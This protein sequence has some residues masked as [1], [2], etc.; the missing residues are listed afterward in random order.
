MIP[1]QDLGDPERFL[2]SLRA[3]ARTIDDRALQSD[4]AASYTASLLAS[5]PT[6]CARKLAEEAIETALAAAASD[7]G[8]TSPEAADLIY[9]LLVLLRSKG[10]ALDEVASI[11]DARSAMSGLDEKRQRPPTSG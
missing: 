9:H 2:A 7:A 8:E 11:L 6:R 4:G 1:R 10:I 3:L 5:G